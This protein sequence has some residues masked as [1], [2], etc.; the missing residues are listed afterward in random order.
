MTPLSTATPGTDWPNDYFKEFC[1]DIFRTLYRVD[2]RRAGKTYLHGLLNCPGRKSIR[3]MA[4]MTP[5]CHS[6]QSLQQFVNQSPWDHEPIRQRLM[7]YLVQAL[8]PQAWV[9]EEVAF[10]KHGRYSAAVER[11][12]ENTPSHSHHEPEIDVVTRKSG[13]LG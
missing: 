10:P 13:K 11:Q 9:I 5:G 4:A 3:R 8:R 6:E 12:F 2:Q 7:N 1:N